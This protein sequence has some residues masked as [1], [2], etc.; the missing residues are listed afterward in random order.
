M[1]IHAWQM[2]QIGM[3]VRYSPDTR[4][5]KHFNTTRC[6]SVFFNHMSQWA[7]RLFIFLSR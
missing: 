1:Q 2:A 3:N 5:L 7:L 6:F 4:K